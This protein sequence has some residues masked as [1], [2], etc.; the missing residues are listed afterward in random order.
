MEPLN[1]Q[2]KKLQTSIYTLPFVNQ[3]LTNITMDKCLI[4]KFSWAQ[5]VE[6]KCTYGLD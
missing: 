5:E 1:M 4:N 6:R 3:V 2:T